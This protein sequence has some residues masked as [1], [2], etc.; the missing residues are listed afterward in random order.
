MTL[1]HNRLETLAGR[2]LSANYHTLGGLSKALF[3]YLENEAPANPKYIFY[4][5]QIPTHEGFK[6]ANGASDGGYWSLPNN[7]DSLAFAL[8]YWIAHEQYYRGN[9]CL[10]PYWRVE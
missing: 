5:N 6:S 1:D 8:F 2:L 7:P 4:N 10:L 9:Q 3:I